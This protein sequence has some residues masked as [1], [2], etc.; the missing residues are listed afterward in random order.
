MTVKKKLSVITATYN[1]G[2]TINKLISAFKESK[3]NYIEWIV[4]DNNSKDNTLELLN[5]NIELIDILVSEPDKG[6]YDA[7][8]KGINFASG[9][10]I[11]FIGSDDYFSNTYFDSVENAILE[12]PLNNI[13]AFKILYVTP[14][15][16]IIF[17]NKD[18]KVPINFPFNLGFFHPGTLHSKTLFTNSLFDINYKIAGDREFLTRMSFDLNPIIF[19][20]AEIQI[21]HNYGGISTNIKYQLLQYKEILKIFN[22]YKYYFNIIFISLLIIRLKY[23]FLKI[24]TFIKIG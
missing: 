4:I 20:T 7:W 11:T 8:N 17:N 13:I 10:Y 18:Y 24:I 15:N 23:I 22:H 2:K 16:T 14:F 3:N 21:T 5:N 6:I 1:S 12:F 9:D 19:Q